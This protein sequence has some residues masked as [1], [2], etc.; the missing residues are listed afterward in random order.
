MAFTWWDAWIDFQVDIFQSV[1]VP[2]YWQV[3]VWQRPIYKDMIRH[4][5]VWWWSGWGGMTY[6]KTLVWYED[7]VETRVVWYAYEVVA[8]E[9]LIQATRE[10]A[11]QVA[12]HMIDYAPIDESKYKDDVVLKE[13]IWI[14]YK[15]NWRYEV[16]A[17]NIPYATRRNYEN[18][19]HPQT[20]HYIERSWEN[21]LNEYQEILSDVVRWWAEALMV[22]E[23]EEVVKVSSWAWMPHRYK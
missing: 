19:L 22:S 16:W 23:L 18:A 1:K 17:R 11:R 10:I 7:I 21:H 4:K 5:E 6:W 14:T 2:Q 9:L 13:N 20:L 3:V 8:N 15:W 12:K